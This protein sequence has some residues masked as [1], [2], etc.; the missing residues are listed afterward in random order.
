MVGGDR[1]WSHN[2]SHHLILEIPVS[3]KAK[4]L[5]TD[6][7]PSHL[8][9]A[10]ANFGPKYEQHMKEMQKAVKESEEQIVE[11]EKVKQELEY[12]KEKAIEELTAVNESLKA[13][14]D[15]K[16]ELQAEVDTVHREM[17]RVR[18]ELRDVNTV[19]ECCGVV[20]FVCGG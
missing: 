10:Q 12:K 3:L 14:E 18:M 19:S 1:D 9:L 6:R 5:S 16:N 2:S 13:E 8:G 11:R 20:G 4:Q 7:R 15:K 17:E